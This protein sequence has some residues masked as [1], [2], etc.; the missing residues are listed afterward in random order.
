MREAPGSGRFHSY[1][2]SRVHANE[3]T[4]LRITRITRMLL[5]LP[6]YR[7]GSQQMELDAELPDGHRSRLH[8]EP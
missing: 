5:L 6:L 2:V 3:I 8:D 1:S 7:S 4:G